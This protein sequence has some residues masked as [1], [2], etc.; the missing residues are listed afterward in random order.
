MTQQMQ[1][2]QSPVQAVEA[3]VLGEPVLQLI[4][5]LQQ[6]SATMVRW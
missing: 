5:A 3:Q 2:S 4:F 6:V 1:R